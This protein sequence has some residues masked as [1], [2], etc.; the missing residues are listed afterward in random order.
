MN[1]CLIKRISEKFFERIGQQ[2]ADEKDSELVFTEDLK[3]AIY[4]LNN[5]PE[6]LELL[7]KMLRK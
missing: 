4:L 5:T 1:K 6:D 3:N 7:E 2:V